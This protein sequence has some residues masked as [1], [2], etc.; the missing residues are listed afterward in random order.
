MSITSIGLVTYNNRIA[1][2]KR[3]LNAYKYANKT[4]QL[5]QYKGKILRKLI[6]L[7]A[8]LSIVSLSGAG[9]AKSADVA[10]IGARVTV[11]EGKVATLEVDIAGAKAA[12]A[13]AA[14]TAA[15]AEAAANRAADLA[16]EINS[17]VSNIVKQNCAGAC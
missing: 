12:A 13:D 5:G 9:C 8:V 6:I 2:P 4:Y 16:A 17:K 10:A 3:G 1:A 14:V 15:V 7:S 11:L